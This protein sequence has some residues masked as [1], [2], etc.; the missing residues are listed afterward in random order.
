MYNYIA[1]ENLILVLLIILIVLIVGFLFLIL[2]KNKGSSF[3]V[4]D[5]IKR[6]NDDQEKRI[7][8]DNNRLRQ[9]ISLIKDATNKDLNEFKDNLNKSI[10]ERFMAISKTLNDGLL[11]I[12]EKMNK[13]VSDNFE[14]TNETF[15]DIRE[16]IAK[17]DEAQKNIKS[18]ETS[19]DSFKDVLENKKMRGN[20]G[21]FQL[22]AILEDVF[23]FRKEIYSVQ[24]LMPNGTKA[25]VLLTLPDPLGKI[26]IDSKFPLDNYRRMYD[27]KYSELERE[28]YRKQFK[29][30]VKKH[31][32]DISSKYI[33][34]NYTTDQAMMFITSEA[35]FAEIQ[36]NM[37][38][39]VE[40]ARSKKVWISSPTTMMAVLETIELTLKDIEISKNS[41]KIL[42]ELN[43]LSEDFT[44]YEKRWSDF[45]KHLGNVVKDAEDINK[46]NKKITSKF[47][48]I[49][50]KTIGKT[51]EEIDVIENNLDNENN[52]DEE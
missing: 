46:S 8:D 20:F 11:Q 14:K 28:Q 18:V 3:D 12:T 29:E 1:M 31:V 25:D 43:K 4:S 34:K 9:D 39:M 45:E 42:E 5:N 2:S 48:N 26:A 49:T 51:I 36:G 23:G 15:I 40:Y 13:N 38:D 37:L 35:V 52:D 27:Y 41:K 16:R 17:I 30:D 21:E 19:I 24:H 6:A 10:D 22:E 32:N 7:L 47:N 44:R 33:I 50:Q